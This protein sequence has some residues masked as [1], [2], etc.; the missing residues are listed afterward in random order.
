MILGFD[1]YLAACALSRDVAAGRLC[2]H[3]LERQK[4][5][6]EFLQTVLT[7]SFH[8]RRERYASHE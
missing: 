3:S 2:V 6:L 5:T 4:G 7:N 8:Q 1:H